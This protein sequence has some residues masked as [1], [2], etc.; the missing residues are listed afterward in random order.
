V[1]KAALP[2]RYAIDGDNVYAIATETP[3]KYYDKTYSDHHRSNIIP[4]KN[5]MVRK[6][7][8]KI[9]V[10]NNNQKNWLPIS[11]F[12]LK[13]IILPIFLNEFCMYAVQL[14]II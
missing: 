11:N 14:L 3:T 10:Q 12:P 5:K 9:K 8:I 6:I 13:K 7:V 4:G 1:T 2:G